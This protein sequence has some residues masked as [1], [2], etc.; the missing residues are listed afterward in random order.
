MVEI[1][2]GSFGS[3]TPQKKEE[4]VAD[5]RSLVELGCVRDSV[6]I[7]E[8]SF[9]LR[10]LSALEKVEAAKSLG[11]AP[12]PTQIFELNVLLLSMS[13]ETVNGVPLEHLYEGAET[14]NVLVARQNVLRNLQSSVLGALMRCHNDINERADAQ[15][16]PEQVKN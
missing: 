4:K 11:E 6:K 7:G 8:M 5:L 3:S 13:I 16:N 10:S 15:F 9:E 1:K 12:D 2:H 14:D